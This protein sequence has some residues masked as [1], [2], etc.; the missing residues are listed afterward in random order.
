MKFEE[1]V[2]HFKDGEISAQTMFRLYGLDQIENDVIEYQKYLKSIKTSK[3]KRYFYK[4][5]ISKANEIIADCYR[6]DWE[7]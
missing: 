2:N 4:G 7:G 1:K 3:H 6:D 5:Y